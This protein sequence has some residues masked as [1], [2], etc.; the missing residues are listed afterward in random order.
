LSRIVDDCTIE[1]LVR[2]TVWISSPNGGR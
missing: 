1:E 2:S